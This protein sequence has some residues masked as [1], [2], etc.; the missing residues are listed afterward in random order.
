[1]TQKNQSQQTVVSCSSNRSQFLFTK[2]LLLF[3]FSTFYR[4]QSPREEKLF[5]HR[6]IRLPFC[7]SS[8]LPT[9]PKKISNNNNPPKCVLDNFNKMTLVIFDNSLLRKP[10]EQP[11][12]GECLSRYMEK[13]SCCNQRQELLHRLKYS[14]GSRRC[15]DCVNKIVFGI[16]TKRNTCMVSARTMYHY[17]AESES[18]FIFDL[19]I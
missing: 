10:L 16:E 7:S 5:R 4:I 17:K 13:I 11:S 9:Q 8:L 15:E 6:E 2:R 19:K 1:M 3:K 12:S 18:L 14:G